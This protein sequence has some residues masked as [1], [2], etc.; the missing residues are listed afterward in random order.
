MANNYWSERI[1]NNTWRAYN[2]VEE[3]NRT[4]LEMYQEATLDIANSIYKLGE[5]IGTATPSLSQ[6]HRLKK[7]NTLKSKLEDR[8]KNLTNDIEKKALNNIQDGMKD[9]YKNIATELDMIDFSEVPERTMKQILNTPWL[10]SS[11]S[12]KL[13]GNASILANNLNDILTIGLTQGKTVTQIAIELNNRM[14]KGF[15][16]CH[17]L[18]RTE[19]MHYFNESAKR[20]YKDSNIQ[21]LEYLTAH[22]ERTCKVCGPLDGKIYD[23]D[24]F[25]TLPIHPNCR[26]TVLPVIEEMIKPLKMNLQLFANKNDENKIKQLIKKGVIADEEYIINKTEFESLFNKGIKTPINKIKDSKDMYPHIIAGHQYMNNIDEIQKIKSNLIK[27]DKIIKTKD[28]YNNEAITF[29]KEIDGEML[30]VVTRN[31][32]IITAYYPNEKYV[33]NNINVGEV[34]WEQE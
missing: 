14:N 18:I 15:N 12:Q 33:K 24:K 30:I 11:F 25:P 19:T 4:L 5:E 13:W 2:S 23:A 20:A 28:K 21:K 34:L 26:C 10:G 29:V 27:P 32:T 6:V 8:I 17:R 9:I 16:S 31:D 7:L 22:D 1:A 3:E